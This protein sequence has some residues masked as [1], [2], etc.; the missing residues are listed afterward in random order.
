MGYLSKY[1]RRIE[2]VNPVCFIKDWWP[3][4]FWYRL[5][6][7]GI[8]FSECKKMATEYAFMWCLKMVKNG[9]L[10]LRF[11]TSACFCCRSCSSVS[12]M[13]F[14]FITE[15]VLFHDPVQMHNAYRQ[16]L[17]FLTFGDDTFKKPWHIFA[18]NTNLSKSCIIIDWYD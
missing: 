5:N 18:K 12:G 9:V 15:P 10:T 13:V 1:E 7:N 3:D 2:N 17:L 11:L 14:F 4:I 6:K 8:R 16:S